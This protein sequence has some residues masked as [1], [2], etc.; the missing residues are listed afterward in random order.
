MVLPP[1]PSSWAGI[2]RV[3]G[4]ALSSPQ[5]EA[6]ARRPVDGAALLA[7]HPVFGELVPAQ[8]QQL[9]SYA[10]RRRVEAGATLFAK[11]DAGTALFAVYSGT[12]KIMVPSLDGREATFNLLYAGEIFGEIALLDGQPRTAD[13]VALT[14]CDL[15]VIERRDFLAFVQATPNVAMK[16]VELLC[17]RLRFASAHLEEVMF[18]SLPAR[19]ARLLTRLRE[20]NTAAD[21]SRLV[22][23]QR[24]IS[25]MLGTTRESVNKQLQSFAK[26]KL[27]ALGRGGIVV[28]APQGLAALARAEDDDEA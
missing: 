25:Q 5:I 3:R 2:L 9:S 17:A 24:E 8:L 1:G 15:M 14:D 23:T 11:G 28:L 6:R 10:R 21:K 16:F 13:A 7:S 12:V 19:L 4:A 26:R 20:E 27:I 22:I 18:L